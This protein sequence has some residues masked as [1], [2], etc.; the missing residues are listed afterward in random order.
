[1]QGGVREEN[2]K[3]TEVELT[4]SGLVKVGKLELGISPDVSFRLT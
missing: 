2:V 1:M 3:F 4:L